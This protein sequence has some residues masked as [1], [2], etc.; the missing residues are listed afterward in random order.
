MSAIYS[1][2][3]N[4]IE[5]D[6][7]GLAPRIGLTYNW[8]KI[9]V[10]KFHYGRYYEFVG[11]GDYNN[12]ART[13]AFGQ[14]RMSTAEHRQGAGVHDRLQRSSA[15]LCARLQQGHEGGVQRRVHHLLRAGDPEEPGLRHDVH[16][17]DD[18]HLLHGGRQRRLHERGVH[19]TG[20]PRLRHDLAAD[21]VRR[22]RAALEVRLQGPPVQ[23]QA[24]LHRQ[25]GHDGQLLPD[26]AEILQAGLRPDRSQAVRLLPLRATST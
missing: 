14:F 2:I 15:R 6:D 7:T 18:Q 19:R 9:G 1:D 24:E 5:F 16:L 4:N 22:G 13:N 26:V 12:Y 21:L 11:T 8:E 23:H 3:H 20:L 10:F 25:V 17:P